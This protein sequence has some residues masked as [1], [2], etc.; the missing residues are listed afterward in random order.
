MSKNNIMHGKP[1]QVESKHK[2]Y[3]DADSRREKLLKKKQDALQVKV[4]RM[5]SGIFHVLTRA[6]IDSKSKPSKK[7]RSTKK[8]TA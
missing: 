1:W 6:I 8:K 4:R 2:S 3:S 5:S 7:K